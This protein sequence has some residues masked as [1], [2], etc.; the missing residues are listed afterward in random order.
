MR[1][2][3][4]DVLKGIGILLVVLG[5]TGISGLPYTFIYA[6]HMPLFFFVSG[7]FYKQRNFLMFLKKKANG[8]LLPYLFFVVCFFLMSLLLNSVQSN[9]LLTGIQTTL[10]TINPADE[11]CWILYRTIWFLLCLFEISV[12]YYIID[13]FA[14]SKIRK[15]GGGNYAV[16][17]RFRS[18]SYV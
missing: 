13:R 4:Y 15:W 17:N 3:E 10:S 2:K 1:I 12:M 16:G 9:N 11:H 6:F 14:N 18:Q 5:H 8:L 7:C